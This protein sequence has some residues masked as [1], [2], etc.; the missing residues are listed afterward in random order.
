MQPLNHGRC[1]ERLPRV[2]SAA[3]NP[4]AHIGSGRATLQSSLTS[5]ALGVIA[6]RKLAVAFLFLLLP[7][8]S[9]ATDEP[10][11]PPTVRDFDSLKFK[12]VAQRDLPQGVYFWTSQ[13][14]ESNDDPAFEGDVAYID[15]NGDGTDEIIVESECKHKNQYEFWQKRKGR[16][17]SLL[18]V[19]GRP[20]LLRKKNGYYQIAVSWSYRDE[21]TSEL[22]TFRGER[23][24]ATR[25]DKY[26]KGIYVGAQSTRDREQV[27]EGNFKGQFK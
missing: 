19:W 3:T 27:L 21:D 10:K 20:E 2:T 14:A 9:R 23:Y 6:M 16:W 13:C 4:A 5:D 11:Y 24:H 15:L 1:S 7:V 18:T 22:Y 12:R 8:A 26:K 17:I 25:I